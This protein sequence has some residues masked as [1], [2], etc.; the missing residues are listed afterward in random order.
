MLWSPDLCFCNQQFML[1]QNFGQVQHKWCLQCNVNLVFIVK[2]VQ[3]TFRKIKTWNMSGDL[4]N[5]MTA[6]TASSFAS[7]RVLASS[8][9]KV[10]KYF[11]KNV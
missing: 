1:E 2:N 9:A 5:S 3:I 6:L 4:T 10:A 7:L 11:T 8:S